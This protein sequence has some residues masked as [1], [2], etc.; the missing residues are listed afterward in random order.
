[1]INEPTWMDVAMTFAMFSGIGSIFAIIA[2]GIAIAYW[3]DRK[4]S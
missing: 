3:I 1:M 4:K 2:I